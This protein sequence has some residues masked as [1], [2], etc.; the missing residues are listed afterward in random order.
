MPLVRPVAKTSKAYYLLFALLLVA[1]GVGF[2]LFSHA[3][4]VATAF[5]AESGARTSPAS[6]ISSTTA[7]GQSA[8]RFTGPCTGA[9]P[10]AHYK[11]VIWIW[12]ENKD[13]GAVDQSAN[14]P[15][16]NQI[17][18]QCSKATNVIDN[19][20]TVA[21]P[22]EPQYAVATSGSN[23]NT[24]I[25]TATGSGT[26]CLR[27]DGDHAAASLDSESIFQLAKN[28]SMS[29]KSYIESM[30]SNCSLASSGRYAYKHNPAAFYNP[31]AADCAIND[32]GIP[33]ITCSTTVGLGCSGTPSNTFT[34]DIASGSLANFTFITPNLDNDMHDGTVAEG[35]NWLKTYVPLITAGPNYASGD[36]AIFIMW[37][38]GS[39]N[40]G[41]ASNI[42][43]VV[44]APSIKPGTV[45]TTATNNIGILRTT[46]QILG[47]SPYLGCASGVAPGGATNCSAGSNVSIAAADNLQ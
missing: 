30:P 18:S 46:E 12:N 6:L 27:T 4:G 1:V 11:H 39:A 28:S 19:A 14:A 8:V 5:E 24:G 43:S 21:L 32:V 26:G 33:A 13:N 22:S 40:S 42:P 23:C 44:I 47:L 16:V 41:T 29:W 3:S 38:E 31:I 15:F 37:D 9:T 20:T 36:T 34:A 45:V 35:D 25:D 7:S 2:K 17:A 10:P